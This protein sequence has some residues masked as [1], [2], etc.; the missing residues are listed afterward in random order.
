MRNL[1]QELLN[2]AFPESC[3]K[4]YEQE[5]MGITSFRQNA[6][7]TFNKHIANIDSMTDDTGHVED[8]KLHYWDFRF[9]NLCNKKCRMCGGHLSSLWN[10][11]ELA[12]YG[13]ASESAPGGV[14]NTRDLSIDNLYELLDQHIEHVEEIYFAGGEPLI[15]EEHYYIIEKLIEEKRTDVKLRY[16]TTLLKLNYKKW[17]NIEL[18]KHFDS[19]NV[20]AS[21]DAMDT[22]G[23]YI[24]KGTVW[25]TIEKNVD[26]ISQEDIMFNISPTINLFNVKTTPKFVDWLRGKGL[27]MG[28]IHLNNVLTTTMVS[29][30]PIGQ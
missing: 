29:Q 11:D 12:V 23:E 14:V 21:L 17:D 19:V 15:M 27:H 1:R 26:R 6:N 2:G 4:C 30:K 24:R 9:S 20:I 22:R 7:F 3:K 16:N 10:A 28:K 18:W 8:M 5:E 13:E 25:S